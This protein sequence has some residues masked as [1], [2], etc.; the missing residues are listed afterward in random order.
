LFATLFLIITFSSVAVPG[1][2]GFVGEFLVL[3]GS[4]KSSL[5]LTLSVLAT[6][7]VILGAAYMLWMVQRVFFGPI[8]HRE[9]RSLLDLNGREI[10][11]ALPFVL[12]VLAMGLLPQPFL[13]R[14]A[15][16][17]SRF[18]ARASL[19]SPQANISDEAVQMVVQP[20]PLQ[21][22]DGTLSRVENR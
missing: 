3:L 1:T 11:T 19:G 15:P 7:A 4:F 9:N 8:S 13:D 14:L 21:N 5:P 18:V 22:V 17:S 16:S 10:A 12:L 2:N 6:T 20:L